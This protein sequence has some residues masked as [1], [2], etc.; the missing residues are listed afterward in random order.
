[1]KNIQVRIGTLVTALLVPFLYGGCGMQTLRVAAERGDATAQNKLG[2]AYYDGKG[3]S[4]DYAEAVKYFR[5]A[6]DQGL[7]EAQFNLGFAYVKGNGVP[8]NYAEAIKWVILAAD[9]GHTEAQYNLGYAYEKGLGVQPNV[10]EAYKWFNL[11]AA[12]GDQGSVEHRD[13]LASHMTPE[14]IAM[15]QKLSTDFAPKKAASAGK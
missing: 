6:A 4:Q 5:L 15:G 10:L 9:Q 13:N 3:V 14:A 7:A 12:K 8:L 11:A 2:N 1:M